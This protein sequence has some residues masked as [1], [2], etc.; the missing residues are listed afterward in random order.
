VNLPRP[1]DNVLAEIVAVGTVQEVACAVALAHLGAVMGLPAQQGPPLD[2]SPLLSAK[3]PRLDALLLLRR[4]TEER[5]PGRL[6]IGLTDRDLYLPVFTH[7]FGEADVGGGVAIA[8]TYRL[9]ADAAAP[10][11]VYQRLAKVACH[12]AGHALGLRHCSH[13]GC[14]MHFVGSLSALDCLALSFCEECVRSLSV[15]RALL[16]EKGSPNTQSGR[17]KDA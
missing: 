8:S 16:V 2:A 7:V 9:R 4:L 14:V 13:P 15:G 12:E 6:R 5:P 17:Q 3:V 1:A 11:L 10:H